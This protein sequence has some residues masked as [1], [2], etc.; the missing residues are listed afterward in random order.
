MINKLSLA[1]KYRPKVFDDVSEQ[2]SIK[3]ILE[4]QI[5][6]NNLKHV[7][8]FC[9]GAGTGKTTCARIVANMFK[10]KYLINGFRYVNDQFDDS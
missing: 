4:N 7:Y 6:T 9:G 5:A 8:L 3:T 10:F 1:N 2:T